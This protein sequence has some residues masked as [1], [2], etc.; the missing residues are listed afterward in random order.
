MLAS[1]M[2]FAAETRR[3]FGFDDLPIF[4]DQNGVPRMLACKPNPGGIKAIFPKKYSEYKPMYTMD[5]IKPLSRRGLFGAQ[6]WILDQ[7]GIGSCVG[8][9]STSS[10][11]KKRVLMGQADLKLSPGC[12]Y[13]QINGGSDNGAVISDAIDALMK[14]G[15]IPYSMI[16]ESPFYTRQMPSGW[17]QQAQRFRITE[18]YHATTYIELLSAIMN[19]DVPF[20]GIMVGNTWEKFDQ[21]GVCGHDRGVGNHC[22][23]ADGIVLLPDG[24]KVMDAS[25][26]WSYSWGPFQNGRMYMDQNHI[27]G[28]GDE[29]DVCIITG[30]CLDPQSPQPP[31]PSA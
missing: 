22:V 7:D 14:V 28:G 10:L 30:A 31:M 11:R 20:F 4:I 16:G 27:D 8:N 9:G 3:R 5:Q 6:D 25:N 1:S 12:T 2:H 24:R 26:S 19:D 13:S 21:Y 23:H 29:P 18:G 17:Q 15:T